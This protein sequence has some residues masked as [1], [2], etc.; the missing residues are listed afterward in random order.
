[1]VVD[2]DNRPN[3]IGGVKSSSGVGDCQR[4]RETTRRRG[5]DEETRRDERWS[6]WVEA[7]TNEQKKAR[8]TNELL[9]TEK[10]EDPNG[11]DGLWQRVTLVRVE[12]KRREEG[13]VSSRPPRVRRRRQAK[14]EGELTLPSMATTGIEPRNP[15]ARED[16]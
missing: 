1:M 14:G 10:L 4:A 9:D 2:H 3:G 12:L 7:H 6:V 15:K 13:K 16:L 8:C 5:R 11:K